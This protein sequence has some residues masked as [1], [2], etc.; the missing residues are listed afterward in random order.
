MLFSLKSIGPGDF[1][2]DGERDKL[3]DGDRPVGVAFL[4]EIKINFIKNRSN[5][6]LKI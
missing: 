3:T 4:S 2:A 1:G 6:V 5:K